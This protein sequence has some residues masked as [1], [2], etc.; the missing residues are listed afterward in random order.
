[1]QRSRPHHPL[2]QPPLVSLNLAQLLRHVQAEQAV[3]KLPGDAFRADDVVK[4]PPL[5]QGT[6]RRV[7]HRDVVRPLSAGLI[8]RYQGIFHRECFELKV[9]WPGR[10][11]PIRGVE[12]F[13]DVPPD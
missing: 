10:M 8:H 5:P 13:G 11:S 2:D 7:E 12:R 4:Q 3:V 1:M 9:A 6:N